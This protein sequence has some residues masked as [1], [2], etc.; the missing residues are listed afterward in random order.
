M[1]KAY[2]YL[3]FSTPDQMRGD[4]FRRQTELAQ[5]YALKHKLELDDQLTFHDLGVSAFRGKNSETGRLAEFLEAVRKG[6]VPAGST[7]LVESL[8]RIS[9]QSAR[10]AV[11]VLEDLCELGITVVTMSD[12]KAYD[13]KT[14]DDDPMSLMMALLIFVR[15]NEESA[16]KS[17]RLKARWERKRETASDVVMTSRCPGWLSL[18]A[19]R[20]WVVD[21]AKARVVR[22]IF[23]LAADGHGQHHIAEVLNS[24]NVPTFGDG[25]RRPGVHWHRSYVARLLANP[26][27]VGILVP[28][29]VEYV[30]R[31]KTRVPQEPVKGYYPAIIER[32]LF[33]AVKA[34]S[35]GKRSP[36]RGRH[37]HTE[38][39]NVVGGLAKCPACGGTMTRVTKGSK[40]RAGRPILVCAKAKVR[41]GCT[42]R[43]VRLEDVEQ[44][45]IDNAGHMLA[46]V[47]APADGADLQDNIQHVEHNI[48]ATRQDIT[49]LI[50][51]L[52]TEPSPALRQRLRE[53]ETALEEW[54]ERERRLWERVS[55]TH[56]PLLEARLDALLNAL[57]AAEFSAAKANLAMRQVFTSVV[58]NYQ[59]GYLELEWL[60]GGQSAY[61][62]SSPFQEPDD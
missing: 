34:L 38:V 28:H 53:R 1:I 14:L 56:G 37:A 58:V 48:E 24:S 60:H 11:R 59:T 45:L 39:R 5:E 32:K 31:K 61:I 47:P 10:K 44:C 57:E 42:Y 22:R 54:V 9:R 21:K 27:V 2:S 36:R 16:M 55:A 50:N 17:R 25:G 30:D 15:S 20:R 51:L 23:K 4:S 41:A 12:G 3:R 62:F 33:E 8:D 49:A 7:L 40:A 13:E 43:S 29:I 35:M 52:S 19:D 26:A 18:T 6:A 46:H